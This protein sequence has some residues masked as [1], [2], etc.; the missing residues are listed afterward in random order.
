MA[1]EPNTTSEDEWWEAVFTEK[2]I[3][4]LLLGCDHQCFTFACRC[5]TE[6]ISCVTNLTGVSYDEQS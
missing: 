4:A 6:A 3:R 2:G 1:G 5:R